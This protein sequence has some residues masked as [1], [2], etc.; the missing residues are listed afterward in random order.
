MTY[1]MPKCRITVLKRTLNQELAD[2]YLGAEGEFGA[3]DQFQEGQQFIVE[4]PFEMPEGFCSWA[5]AD[6][7]G[8]ILAIMAGANYP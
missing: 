4:K 1:A 8:E 7:R 2:Q 3:C 5:W 6:L